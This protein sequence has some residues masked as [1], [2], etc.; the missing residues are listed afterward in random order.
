MIEL[1]LALGDKSSM[2]SE[3]KVIKVSGAVKVVW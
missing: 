3:G 1:L 2:V